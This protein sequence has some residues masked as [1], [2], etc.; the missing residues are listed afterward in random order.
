LKR[1]RPRHWTSSSAPSARA[2]AAALA[3]LVLLAP[4]AA[5]AAPGIVKGTVL[6]QGE[7]AARGFVAQD[8]VVILRG[9]PPVPTAPASGKAMIDQRSR[10]FEPRV[11]AIPAGTTVE[12]PNHDV[13]FHNVY[14]RS[15]VHPFDLGIYPPGEMRSTVFDKPGVVEV[16]CTAH[17]EMEA[18]VVVS[19]TPHFA[20]VVAAGRYEIR[21]VAPGTY[22]AEV[23]HPD[24]VP[25]TRQVTVEEHVPVL[26][27]D[28]TLSDRRPGH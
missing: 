1:G 10:R 3:A 18:W 14:S 9:G 12:F 17:P 7:A 27:I 23:W 20:P 6:L 4:V 22:Q 26:T 5:P 2:V 11:L 15:P 28:F 25:V 21:D 19:E 24:A 8:A 16:R 13:I